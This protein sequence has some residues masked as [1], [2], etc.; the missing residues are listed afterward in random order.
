MTMIDTPTD[1][2]PTSLLDLADRYEVRPTV[3]ARD[4]GL[5]QALARRFSPDTRL[6]VARDRGETWAGNPYAMRRFIYPYDREAR[7]IGELLDTYGPRHLAAPNGPINSLYV[8]VSKR[9]PAP[10]PNAVNLSGMA[11]TVETIRDLVPQAHGRQVCG[12]TFER[13]ES[14]PDGLVWAHTIEGSR[15]PFQA[16]VLAG[17]T[18]TD[19]RLSIRLHGKGKA[20]RV[21]DQ[22]G[23]LFGVVMPIRHP[24]AEWVD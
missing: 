10:G 22:D 16:A 15:V 3:R 11:P 1:L 7:V 24:A 17:I 20:A 6:I 18:C 8:T 12:Y 13:S 19:R 14:Y 9:G 4:T 21:L 2:R 5:W 23:T